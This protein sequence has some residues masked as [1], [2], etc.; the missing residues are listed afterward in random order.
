[1]LALRY[2]T[3][4][5]RAVLTAPGCVDTLDPEAQSA[6][7][8][9]SFDAGRLSPEPTLPRAVLTPRRVGYSSTAEQEDGATRLALSLHCSCS[10]SVRRHDMQFTRHDLPGCPADIASTTRRHQVRRGVVRTVPVEMVDDKRARPGPSPRSPV[11]F[12]PTPVAWMRSRSDCVVQ[13]DPVPTYLSALSSDG[14][15]GNESVFVGRTLPWHVDNCSRI[16]A[17]EFV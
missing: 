14:V 17:G 3:A 4:R 12:A 1:M 16:P 5:T 13:H 9:S 10:R 7:G 6:D 2:V 8:T 11:E 15:T